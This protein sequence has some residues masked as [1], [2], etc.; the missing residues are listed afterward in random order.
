MT[1]FDKLLVEMVERTDL[2]GN[3][4]ELELGAAVE[5][6]Y[7]WIKTKGS[8][9]ISTSDLEEASAALADSGMMTKTEMERVPAIVLEL[10]EVLSKFAKYTPTQ[11]GGMCGLID[12]VFYDP[13]AEFED[14]DPIISIDDE[15]E[16]EV[17]GENPV[18]FNKGGFKG[19]NTPSGFDMERSVPEMEKPEYEK[20]QTDIETEL[21]DFDPSDIVWVEEE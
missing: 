13:S 21:E 1:N 17:E 10:V 9:G 7:K 2:G 20:F 4:S 6:V 18:E 12:S 14:A 19:L 11:V 16:G 3:G 5:A 8:A 15:V